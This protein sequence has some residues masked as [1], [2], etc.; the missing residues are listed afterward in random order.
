MMTS[1]PVL[2]PEYDDVAE[3]TDTTL[4]RRPWLLARATITARPE[5]DAGD[6]RYDMGSQMTVVRL[7]SG[8]QPA[9]DMR[10]PPASK[11]ADIEKGEDQKDRWR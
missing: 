3:M 7:S 4:E 9:I 8:E 10:L 2:Q 6:T 5:V 1:V 11:K